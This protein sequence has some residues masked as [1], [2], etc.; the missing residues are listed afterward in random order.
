MVIALHKPG[1]D[2]GSEETGPEPT[3][4]APGHLRGRVACVDLETTG[5]AA[6]YHRVIEVGIVLLEGGVVVEEWSS[7]VNPGGYIPSGITA[8][9]GID[10]GM[11]ADAPRF[12]ELGAAIL[13]R[14]EGCLFVAHN[15]GFDYG[16]LRSEFRRIGMRFS[17][18]RLCTVRLS[19]RLFPEE[20]GHSLDAL[21]D[22]HALRCDA[23]HRALGDARVLPALLDA[24]EMR[25]GRSRIDEAVAAQI[26]ATLLPPG[27]PAD[28]GDDLPELPGVYVFRGEGGVPLYVGMGRNLRSRVLAHFSGRDREAAM[29]RDLRDVEWFETGGEFGALLLESRLIRDLAP[30]A[31]RRLRASDGAWVI[32]LRGEAAGTTVTIEPIGATDVG[33]EDDVYGP[34]GSELAA[35]RVLEG[36]ARDTH[37]CLKVIGLESGEGSCFAR[38][39]G[40]CRGACSGVEPRALH[41]ARLRLALAPL[42][43]RSWPFS[44]A[45]AIRE[46]AAGS[47][48]SVLHVIDRWQHVGS[49]ASEEEL[50]ALAGTRAEP[51]FDAD[52]YRIMNRWLRR[53]D[54]RAC[55]PLPAGGSGV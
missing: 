49:A 10:T 31:H 24:L 15:A 5:G 48:G 41:D 2:P 23:R 25:A 20:H 35:R 50:Q 19:R 22:R 46:P 55:I 51:G 47:T 52:M 43:L 42:R 30:L 39:L 28:L 53:V 26:R 16:F 14:L 38:L 36:R 54:A 8:L 37:L 32:R 17:A 34:F 21:I 40:R 6:A 27:L 45:V 33:D 11:V 12:E 7:L 44:G 1:T 13:R 29:V 3:L 4:A 9:T 18:P